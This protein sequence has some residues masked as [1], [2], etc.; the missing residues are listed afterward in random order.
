MFQIPHQSS[1][2]V[3]KLVVVACAAFSFFVPPCLGSHVLSFQP[4]AVYDSRYNGTNDGNGNPIFSPT[5]TFGYMPNVNGAF[6]PTYESALDTI[7]GQC[8]ID[9]EVLPLQT[10]DSATYLNIQSDTVQDTI[11]RTGSPAPP[12]DPVLEA[13]ISSLP[14]PTS[15]SAAHLVFFLNSQNPDLHGAGMPQLAPTAP[16]TINQPMDPGQPGSGLSA[17]ASG[18][19]VTPNVGNT[20][21]M[22]S[23][24]SHSNNITAANE[25]TF[26]SSTIPTVLAHEMM[27]NLSLPHHGTT[28]NLMYVGSSPTGSQAD[29]TTSQCSDAIATGLANGTVAAVPEPSQA[30][31]WCFLA[32][33]GWLVRWLR[34]R[35]SILQ[36]H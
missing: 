13:F 18:V 17:S 26:A 28:S 12:A 3:L 14:A 27:H 29:L 25:S 32:V 5:G 10:Y 9:V 36:G 22:R 30:L 19:A 1:N 24:M 7:Y 20:A 31:S 16:Q 8:M 34:I 4:I 23:L 35:F 2:K 11:L 6:A 33:T 15:T 21:P